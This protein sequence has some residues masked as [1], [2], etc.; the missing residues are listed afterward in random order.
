MVEL[1]GLDSIYDHFDFWTLVIRFLVDLTV[2]ST[3]VIGVYAR[4]H[5]DR[6]HVFTCIL[7]NVMTFL[8]CFLLRKV[9]VELGFALGLFAV[10]GILRYRTEPMGIRDLTY[11]FLA[12]GVAILNAVLNRKVSLA[13]WVFGNLS[14]VGAAA[15]FEL[16]PFT[17]RSERRTVLYDNLELLAP[18]RRSELLADLSR[19]TG[20]GV[21]SVRI[22]R[23]D[24]LRDSAE[25][26]VVFAP[27]SAGEGS[28]GT[29][30]P[31][32]AVTPDREAP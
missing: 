14:I 25:L 3:L 8:V 22:E 12:I 32:L 15:L 30:D 13:E 7:I 10:F 27:H 1:I 28:P 17:R 18:A 2:V 29:P 11:L 24:L 6:D 23:I 20:I 16:L 31:K 26:S 4:R 9:P 19:R 5:H 21:E